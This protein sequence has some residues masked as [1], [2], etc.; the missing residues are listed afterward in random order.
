MNVDDMG[1]LRW[2]R[3]RLWIEVYLA[4]GAEPARAHLAEKSADTAVEA[5]DKRF[6]T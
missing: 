2:D 3:R 1:Q 5:F 4:T 6:L